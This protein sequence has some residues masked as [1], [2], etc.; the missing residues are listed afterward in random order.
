[1][2]GLQLITDKTWSAR[3]IERRL[4]DIVARI[5]LNLAGEFLPLLRCRLRPYQ[6]SVPT[7]LADCLYNQLIQ[8][9]QYMLP[10]FRVGHQEC[11]DV[12]KDGILAQ[13]IANNVRNVRVERLVIGQ[14]GS[15]GVCD[16]YIAGPIG[17]KKP[18]RSKCRVGAENQRIAEVVVHSSIDDIDALESVGGAHVDDVVVSYEI[19]AFDKIDSHLTSEIGMFEVCGIENT[20]REKHDIRLWSPLGSQ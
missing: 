3:E 11:L 19:A 18:R 15:K 9:G 4:S 2:P 8:I 13:I 6:H 10:I 20:R 5:G 12:G 17:I 16:R 1:M 14:A 7:A